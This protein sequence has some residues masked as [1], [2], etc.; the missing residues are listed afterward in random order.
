MRGR[1]IGRRTGR[2]LLWEVPATLV[3]VEPPMVDAI[4]TAFVSE[5]DRDI[6]TR[7]R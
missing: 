1:E 6:A 5:S 7:A 4:A 3:D 2:A